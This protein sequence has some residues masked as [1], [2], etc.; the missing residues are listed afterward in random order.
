M[1]QNPSP[2]YAFPSLNSPA[3]Y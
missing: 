1:N 3:F 2:G